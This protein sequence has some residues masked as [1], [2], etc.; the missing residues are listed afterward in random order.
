MTIGLPATSNHNFAG[1]TEHLGMWLETFG[2]NGNAHLTIYWRPGLFYGHIWC[3]TTHASIFAQKCGQNAL[4]FT[5]R[6]IL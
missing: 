2:Y 4:C 5:K 3:Y 6:A 1:L